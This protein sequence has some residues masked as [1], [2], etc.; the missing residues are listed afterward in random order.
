MAAGVLLFRRK[1]FLE[2]RKKSL[3][4]G[5]IELK[6]ERSSETLGRAGLVYA[7][8]TESSALKVAPLRM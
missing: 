5:G 4:V 7:A 6:L 8:N 2:D 1:Q 3:T